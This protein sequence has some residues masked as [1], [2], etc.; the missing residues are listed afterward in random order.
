V[1]ACN[2]ALI[3]SGRKKSRE[4]GPPAVTVVV[5][6]FNGKN[7]IERA[8]DSVF[9]QTFT[10]VEIIVVDDGSTDLTVEAISRKYGEQLRIIEH[11]KNRGAAA[12]R[13]TGIAAAQARW[14]AFLD[15]DDTWRPDKLV[16]QLEMLEKA[17]SLTKACAT[18]F[19]LHKDG[20]EIT[21]K[22]K[23][24]SE[25]FRREVL[26]GCTISPGST[27]LVDRDV[28][29][30]IGMFDESLLRLEDWDWLLRFAKRYDMMFVPTLLADI[31]VGTRPL[32]Q[33]TSK[34]E[35]ALDCIRRK[36]LSQLPM[37]ASMRLRGSL[38]VEKAAM[39]YR[40]GRRISAAAHIVAALFIYPFRNTAFF[41]ML[42]RSV[43][44][45]R[46]LPTERA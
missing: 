3:V 17:G 44:K 11:R 45:A 33:D 46:N 21:F 14:V 39:F 8:L 35:N 34:I 24:S 16:R 42:W 9:A 40:A 19:Q 37:L 2:Q 36:H 1:P 18:G 5:P 23:F 25:Q 12:A 7:T 27:L 15:C 31:Y 10:D 26:F 22:T 29:N 41:R 38:L 4:T 32:Q 30:D 20:R 43:R 6:V 28:F 13:N